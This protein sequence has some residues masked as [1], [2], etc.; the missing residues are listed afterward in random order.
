[1]G[2]LRRC[3]VLDWV[4][5]G[6]CVKKG[7]RVGLHFIFLTLVWESAYL[8]LPHVTPKFQPRTEQHLQS[9]PKNQTY[10][11]EFQTQFTYPDNLP[12]TTIPSKNQRYTIDYKARIGISVEYISIQ[13]GRGYF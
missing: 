2:R 8:L 12:L 6:W 9:I 3:R 4:W 7:I 5:M 10:I 13:G 1:M 11:L